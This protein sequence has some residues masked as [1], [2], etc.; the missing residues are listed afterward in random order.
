M[1]KR[2]ITGEYIAGF[3]D[4]EGCFS[5]TLRKDKN[6]YFYWKTQFAI[7]L[8]N[9]DRGVLD[10][11]KNFFV[12]GAITYSNDEVRYQIADNDLLKK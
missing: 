7:T 6:K 4:G 10:Q 1:N 3:V 5:L 12:C 9:D 11:I 8:R 2:E